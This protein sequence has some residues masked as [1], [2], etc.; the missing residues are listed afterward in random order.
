[1]NTRNSVIFH[2]T[3]KPYGMDGQTDAVSHYC[4][5]CKT[6]HTIPREDWVLLVKENRITRRQHLGLVCKHSLQNRPQKL[7]SV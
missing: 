2:Y 6:H 7:H 5:F 3:L 4:T 1:M